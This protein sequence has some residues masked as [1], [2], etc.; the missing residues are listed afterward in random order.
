MRGFIVLVVCLLPCIQSFCQSCT[1]LGQNPGTAFPICGS[2]SDTFRQATVP[3]CGGNTVPAPG[4][5]NNDYTDKNPFWYRFTCYT[6]GTLGFVITP[7]TLAEDYDWQI[8]DITGR[9][10]N[11]VFSN[12]SL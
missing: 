6:S 10:P 9:S 2:V 4:C 8:F 1:T 12:P 11:E 3:I 5:S 7:N